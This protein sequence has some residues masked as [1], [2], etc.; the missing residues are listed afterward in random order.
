MD[1]RTSAQPGTVARTRG[2]SAAGGTTRSWGRCSAGSF[3]LRA[4]AVA[5]RAGGCTVFAA[6][7]V[8]AFAGAFA[9]FAGAFSAT[10][11]GAFAVRDFAR[12][13]AVLALVGFC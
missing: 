2:V 7:V 13:L 8:I 1:S 11:A 4:G 12:P 10:F 6:F 9:F 3:P 5:R